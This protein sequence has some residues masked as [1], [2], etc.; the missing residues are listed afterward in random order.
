[1]SNYLFTTDWFSKSISHWEKVLGKFKDKD[2]ILALEIGSWEGR[3]SI[4]LCEN[5]LTGKGCCLSCIDTFHGSEENSPESVKGLFARFK[6][7]TS[8]FV[9][10]GVIRIFKGYSQY[11]LCDLVSEGK[12]Y[13]IIYIDGSHQARDVLTDTTLSWLL[14]KIGGVLIFDD[15]DWKTDHPHHSIPRPAINTFLELYNPC[16]KLLHKSYQVSVEKISD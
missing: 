2:S 3:S 8:K 11:I 6:H 15:Y 12:K 7:N 1:M 5:I 4:W 16:Y 10:K 13:D 9:E 14:L